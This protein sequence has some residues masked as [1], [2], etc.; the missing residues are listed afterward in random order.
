MTFER[1]RGGQIVRANPV[2]ENNPTPAQLA[3]RAMMR[4]A[5][6]IWQYIAG[7]GGHDPGIQ[8]S[9]AYWQAHGIHWDRAREQWKRSYF[10]DYQGHPNIAAV[11]LI[12]HYPPLPGPRLIRTTVD[13]D[14]GQIEAVYTLH[15]DRSPLVIFGGL[16]VYYS[17]AWPPNSTD[18]IHALGLG[19]VSDTVNTLGFN[20]LE[21]RRG[22]SPGPW[23]LE[24][25]NMWRDTSLPTHDPRYFVISSP[26]VVD[27]TMPP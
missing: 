10:A 11:N 5:V 6:A 12:P 16:M 23:R 4:N 15:R 18:G 2:Q 1:R 25:A 24:C 9:L 27:L 17:L 19:L 7:E 21:T 3:Q 22:L 26:L 14:Q 8:F 20:I 13:P